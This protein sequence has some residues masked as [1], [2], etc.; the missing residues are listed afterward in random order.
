MVKGQ[1]CKY[2][3]AIKEC[4]LL[5]E[6]QYFRIEGKAIPTYCRVKKVFGACDINSQK[7]FPEFDNQH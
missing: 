1:H 3:P 4:S 6:G 2:R 7:E 5:N